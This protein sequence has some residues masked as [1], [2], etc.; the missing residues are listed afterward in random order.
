MSVGP[1]SGARTPMISPSSGADRA[2]GG[3]DERARRRRMGPWYATGRLSPLSKPRSPVNRVESTFAAAAGRTRARGRINLTGDRGRHGVYG[4]I[5]RC[6]TGSHARRRVAS[7]PS[8]SSSSPSVRQETINDGRQCFEPRTSDD[9][10][11][12]SGTNVSHDDGDESFVCINIIILF[13]RRRSFGRYT[14]A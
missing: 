3:G 2:R 9:G 1:V 8:S 10:G 5:D 4:Q 13:F 7:R 14:W 11:I 6:L 12:S